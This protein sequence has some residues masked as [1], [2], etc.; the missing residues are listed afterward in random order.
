MHSKPR[1]YVRISDQLHELA[2]LFVEEKAIGAQRIGGSLRVRAG[3][4]LL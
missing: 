3:L 4:V 2:T 1:Q